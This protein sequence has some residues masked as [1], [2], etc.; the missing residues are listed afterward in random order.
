MQICNHC[1][2]MASDLE[3]IVH[4]LL[5][6]ENEDAFWDTFYR[7]DTPDEEEAEEDEEDELT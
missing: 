3:P 7:Q 1:G 4:H 5:C 6:Q 2:A